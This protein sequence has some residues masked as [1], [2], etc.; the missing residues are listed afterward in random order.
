MAR[1]IGKQRDIKVCCESCNW[2]MLG[3]SPNRR[4]KRKYLRHLKHR[5]RQAL[6]KEIKDER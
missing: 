6:K 2:P 3:K 5:E 1:M 4:H